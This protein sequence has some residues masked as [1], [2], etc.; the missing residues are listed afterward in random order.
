VVPSGPTGVAVAPRDPV[1]PVVGVAVGEAD[2]VEMTTAGPP[3]LEGD[4]PWEGCPDGPPLPAALAP[5]GSQLRG[6]GSQLRPEPTKGS[7]DSL[8]P[9][10]QSRDPGPRPSTKKPSRMVRSRARRADATRSRRALPNLVPGSEPRRIVSV[11]TSISL[12]NDGDLWAFL[13]R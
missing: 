8:S 10:S 7:Q 13:R 4:P 6:A 9:L 5:S 3:P 12:R 11:A 1:V 2:G